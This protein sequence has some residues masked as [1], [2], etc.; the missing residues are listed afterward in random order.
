MKCSVFVCASLLV[1][2]SSAAGQ[3]TPTPADAQNPDRVQIEATLQRYIAAY[4]HRSSSELLAVWPDLEKQ[5]KEYGKIR[6]H[7]EDAG[8]S[9]EQ[10]AVQPVKVETTGDRVLLQARRT[11][12]F[13]KSETASTITTGDLNMGNAAQTL[14]PVKSEKKKEVKKTDQVWISLQKAGG[15]WTITSIDATK[16]N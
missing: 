15:V 16:P 12:Q 13:M 2:V 10:M 14:P 3:S 8:V 4:V 11:E 9:D 6:H 1:A 5:K 7:F